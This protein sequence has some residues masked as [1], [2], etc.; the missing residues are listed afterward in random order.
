MNAF[1]LVAGTGYIDKMWNAVGTLDRM[2]AMTCGQL[3]KKHLTTDPGSLSHLLFVRKR[4]FFMCLF[5]LEDQLLELKR[6]GDFICTSHTYDLHYVPSYYFLILC[7]DTALAER[8]RHC[9]V[10][11]CATLAGVLAVELDK[12]VSVCTDVWSVSM[13]WRML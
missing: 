6:F 10:A 3:V 4:C 5:H 2:C 11:S 13:T 9:L 1:R 8:I 12:L 7:T